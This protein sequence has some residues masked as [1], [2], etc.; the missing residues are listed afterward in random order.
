MRVHQDAIHHLGWG[1]HDCNKTP[2][3]EPNHNLQD[4]L[5]DALSSVRP[6]IHLHSSAQ[7][8][9]SGILAMIIGYVTV[10]PMIK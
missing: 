6:C 2:Y 5:T 7:I 1:L 3:V 9:E 10:T 8:S 4:W